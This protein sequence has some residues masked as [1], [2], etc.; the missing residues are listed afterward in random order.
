VS[1]YYES[2]DLSGPSGVIW[3]ESGEV[4]RWFDLCRDLTERWVHQ[5]HIR[6]AVKRPGRHDRFLPIVLRT[7]VWAFPH[8]Y[9]VE[10]PL[11][12]VVQLGLGTG[13]TWTLTRSP[14]RWELDEGLVQKY[15]AALVMSEAVAWRQLTE[16]SVP[17]AD[18]SMRGSEELLRPLLD[19]RGIIA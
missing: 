10:A 18:L 4:P 12:T 14:E 1:Q 7:F 16:L 19:V 6:D 5:Q 13:G 2:L 9:R 15:A 17:P 3:A 8:Q 11:N